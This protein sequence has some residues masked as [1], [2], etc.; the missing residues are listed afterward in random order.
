MSNATPDAIDLAATARDLLRDSGGAVGVWPRAAAV[1]ARQA[2]ELGLDHLWQ[3]RAPGMQYTSARCQML[4]LPEFLGDEELAE[5]TSAA[6]WSLSRVLHHHPYE[7]VPTH[8]ELMGWITVAWDVAN[9][10]EKRSAPA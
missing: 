1:L 6:W 2:I 3:L 8:L 10:V 9:A 7:L 4:C 5:R